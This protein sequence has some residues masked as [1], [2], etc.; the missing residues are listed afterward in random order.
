VAAWR[1]KT[2]GGRGQRAIRPPATTARRRAHLAGPLIL[3]L[4]TLHDGG[5][6]GVRVLARLCVLPGL[7]IARHWRG[8]VP[9]GMEEVPRSRPP[10][11]DLVPHVHDFDSVAHDTAE[12]NVNSVHS[13]EFAGRCGDQ[14]AGL[15]AEY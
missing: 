1:R 4:S 14:E 9:H 5:P 11:G 12:R 7:D 2:W 15:G 13:P 3:P 10:P 8:A 6:H